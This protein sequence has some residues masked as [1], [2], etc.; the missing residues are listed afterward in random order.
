[1]HQIKLNIFILTGVLL[2]SCSG[3]LE[4]DFNQRSTDYYNTEEGIIELSVGCYYTIF[5]QPFSTEA[6][7]CHTNYGTD[8]F[9]VGGDASN[10][11]WNSYDSGFKSE[12]SNINS[13]TV[14][15]DRLWNDLY[16]GIGM[17]NQLIESATKIESQ[18]DAVKKTALGEGYFFRA[19]NYLRLVR[20]WGAVPL[21]LTTS[22]T[23]E[24]EFTRAGARDVLGQVISDFNQAYHLLQNGGA[25]AKITK[26][27]CAHFLA[28]ALLTRASEIND[29]WNSETKIS[30]LERAI[31]LSDEVIANHPL[32]HNFADLWNFTMPDGPNEYLPEIILSAQFTSNK[33]SAGLNFSPVVFVSR[34]DDLPYMQRDLSGMRPYSRLAPTYLLYSGFNQVKDSRFWKSFRTKHRLNKASGDYRNGDVGIMYVINQ[35]DDD[36]FPT[37]AN[38]ETQSY[39]KTGRKIPNVYAAY[40][41]EEGKSLLSDVRYPSC[42][43]HYDASRSTVNDTRGQRDEILARSAETYLMAAEAKIK[44]ARLNKSNYSDALPYL[45]AVRLRASYKTGE[46]RSYYSDGGVSYLVSEY[47]QNPDFTSIMFEN[48]YYESNN[49]AVTTAAADLAISDIATL[50]AEDLAV[51]TKLGYSSD[52]DKMMCLVLDERSRELC[53]EWLRWE[54]LSRTKTLVERAKAFNPEAAKNIKDFHCLRP[55]PQTFLDAIQIDG[56]ALSPAEKQAR[57]NPG[58]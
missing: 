44:L 36:R 7:Y 29:F 57:Q 52:Y 28:K 17:A 30:D 31:T 27:A 41:K 55:I 6:M 20:Q 54:D 25:P 13:N 10:G 11:A 53:G 43:K 45:N 18:N 16:I 56:R 49:I 12:I 38:F 3:F 2:S 5:D 46:D 9:H 14:P 1:M 22:K 4:E 15:I 48:S 26:D 34:Y 51:I 42:N 35:P 33:A 23:I 37:I 39:S 50:P 19:Y 58:Y 47:T 40:S 21:K 8:E 32:T 24:K